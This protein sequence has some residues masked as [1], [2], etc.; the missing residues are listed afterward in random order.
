[1][2]KVATQRLK[3]CHRQLSWSK[4]ANTV[5]NVTNL[6]LYVKGGFKQIILTVDFI[7]GA[8]NDSVAGI[9]KKRSTCCSVGKT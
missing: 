8:I 9:I 3:K 5:L 4:E 2:N 6:L 1:M 7:Q